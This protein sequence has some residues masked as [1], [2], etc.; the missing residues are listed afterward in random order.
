MNN[1]NNTKKQEE[2]GQ[3]LN[4][5]PSYDRAWSRASKFIYSSQKRYE[6]TSRIVLMSF[7][8]TLNRFCSQD[9]WLLWESVIY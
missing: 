1:F 3:K 4:Y 8:S 6:N 9:Q 2:K 7:V 5:L